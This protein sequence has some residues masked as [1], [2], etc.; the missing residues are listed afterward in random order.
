MLRPALFSR[1]AAVAA[2]VLAGLL[3]FAGVPGMNVWPVAF[4]AMVPLLLA[5]HGRTPNAAAALGLVSGTVASLGGFYWLYGMLRVFS[6]MPWP[7]CVLLMIAMCAYQGGRTALS[8]WAATRA[9][10][11][12]WPAALAFVLAWIGGELL[13]P[14]LF[15]WYFAF[16]MH[17]TPLFMQ[18][19][20]LGGVY[21]VGAILLGPNVAIAE[22]VRARI[23]RTQF[24][25][26][27]VV[28]GLAAPL[29]GAG[30]GLVRMPGVEAKAAAGQAVTVGIVQ[31]NLPLF[32]RRNSLE[33]QRRLTETLRERA[34]LVL[35]SESSVP[36]V[37]EEG[38]FHDPT[39]GRITRGLDVPVLFGAGEK[40]Q[41][42][43]VWR[44]FNT[45]F[46]ADIDGNVVGR[47]DKQYLLPF[48]EFI[49]FG[50]TF[51]WLYEKSPHSG[52]LTPGDSHKPLEL[53]GHR[54]T[55]LI[56][57]ED[58][59]PFYVN[60]AV[61]EGNPELLVNIALDTWFGRTI[62]PWEHLA[63]A[64]LRAVEHRRYLARATNSGVSA[65]VDPVGRVIVHGGL[66]SEETLLGEVRLMAPTTVYEI[67]GD[68]PWY[69][70]ALIVVVMAIVQRPG[71]EA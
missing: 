32:E 5:I 35:W 38:R 27:I 44:E 57:Y 69:V 46:L 16:M 3:Y 55:V 47:Y 62:E 14:L 21:L 20:D 60:G 8:C 43:G 45:A 19:A 61:R 18:V 24:D 25:R 31:G 28:A 63:L 34:H 49:P 26:R 54:I 33:I 64:Q 59:L 58:I 6:G 66:F 68:L 2:A 36:N 17:R 11:N 10:R 37:F 48:G 15:P 50:N 51:P 29:L 7:V 23:E 39:Y 42:D 65:I 1:P 71:R 41:V 67:L 30:Y 4:V 13:Y 53:A 70:A 12:G 9:A 56:C 52:R 40:R 22:F